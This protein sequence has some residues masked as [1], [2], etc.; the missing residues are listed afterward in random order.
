MTRW[1]VRFRRPLRP[2]PPPYTSTRDGLIIGW[3]PVERYRGGP[4]RLFWNARANLW[5]PTRWARSLYRTRADAE[6]V[7]LQLIAQ[8]PS[9]TGELEIHPERRKNVPGYT[10]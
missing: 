3:T 6:V 1:I 9:L 2:S 4:K 10:V 8:D 5:T 7:A